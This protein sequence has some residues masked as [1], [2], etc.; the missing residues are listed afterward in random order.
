MTKDGQSL[1][2]YVHIYCLIYISISL[3][4]SLFS[5]RWLKAVALS[6]PLTEDLVVGSLKMQI[7]FPKDIYT[8][9]LLRMHRRALKVN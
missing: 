7:I 2:M 4:L 5:Q 8:W 9:A 6:K 3:C 1:T